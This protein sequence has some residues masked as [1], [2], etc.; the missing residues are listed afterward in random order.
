M[1]KLN[2]GSGDAVVVRDKQK[3]DK[4]FIFS[5]FAE[6]QQRDYG[7]EHAEPHYS[8]IKPC[9][10]AEKVL[11]EDGEE[12]TDYKILCI[13]GTPCNVLTTSQR[14]IST[15]SAILNLYDLNWKKMNDKMLK[16]YHNSLEVPKPVHL[17]EMLEYASRLS[18]GFPQVRVD[19]YEVKEKVYFG[20][21]TFTAMAG[22]LDEY[23]PKYQKELGQKIRNNQRCG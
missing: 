1:L 20:E 23:T 13:N 2:N 16:V 5:H 10:I 15:H 4:T 22:R 12:L 11:N 8:R 9:I 21:M 17:T 7:F 6:L 3:M 14:D 19:F 18:I